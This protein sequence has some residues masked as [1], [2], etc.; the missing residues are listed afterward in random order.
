MRNFKRYKVWELSHQLVLKIYRITSS[1]PDNEKYAMVSQM[2][3]AAYSI[4]SN[5]AEG[6]GRDSDKEF[7]R[8]I[9]ISQGS[10]YELEYF[11]LLSRDLG[12]IE[13]TIYKELDRE[14][15]NIKS[16][17]DAL[18]RKLRA[19]AAPSGVSQ[20]AAGTAPTA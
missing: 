19:T 6:S 5:F 1:F 14:I 2:R 8:F 15:N 17:L 10:L 3:R 12:L 13:D 18:S 4:P 11:L 16:M 20:S 9:Q 7:N